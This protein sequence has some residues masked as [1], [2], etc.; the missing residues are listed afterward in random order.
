MPSQVEWL[1][2]QEGF[3]KL[4]EVEQ[5]RVLAQA[6]QEDHQRAIADTRDYPL[7][8][9]RET[10][11]GLG[12]AG[13]NLLLG[14]PQTIASIPELLSRGS[15]LAGKVA[16]GDLP[17]LG[18]AAGAGTKAMLPMP[19]V[20]EAINKREM[21]RYRDVVTDV[22]EMGGSLL[23]GKAISKIPQAF[24]KVAPGAAPALHELAIPEVE[25]FADRFRPP[26]G[27][28]EEAYAR[29]RQMGNPTKELPT[30]RSE[31]AKML[32]EES[33]LSNPDTD[34][35][36]QAQNYLNS[37][38][39][40]WPLDQMVAEEQR[41]GA[42]LGQMRRGP[43]GAT[44]AEKVGGMSR[45]HEDR[46]KR[47]YSALM[48]DS[49][50][51]LKTVPSFAPEVAVPGEVGTA[52]STQTR[53][54]RV[55]IE[56]PI[57]RG[58]GDVEMGRVGDVQVVDPQLQAWHRQWRRAAYLHRREM[59]ANGLKR[60][61]Q[62]SIATVAG[63]DMAERINLRP[64]VNSIRGAMRKSATDPQARLFAESFTRPEL[65]DMIS[66]LKEIQRRL[67]PIPPVAGVATGT[68][69]RALIGS[70]GTL[71]GAGTEALMGG[72]PYMGGMVGGA[73][74]IVAERILSSHYISQALT[75][76]AGRAMVK[77][78]VRVDPT[79]GSTFQHLVGGYLRSQMPGA[80]APEAPEA[81]P[82][83]AAPPAP[84]PLPT[85]PAVR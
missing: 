11:A 15:E 32:A 84:K 28:A 72:S 5:K 13:K 46:I 52:V 78:A 38:D 8:I 30:F 51:A 34:F 71:A 33:R 56:G 58:P 70:I 76:D 50:D 47:M 26:A 40:G 54:G 19:R 16:A 55:A 45:L 17:A 18:Q 73:A 77:L 43:R 22:G 81:T 10:A 80:T 66:T 53:P 20:R 57:A 79:L 49:E 67:P 7:Y 63:G 82:T 24:L 44:P 25:S 14:V 64:V 65:K 21:P 2:Q 60:M 12:K 3:K 39:K 83:A 68:S 23:A 42:M 62:D 36:K 35:I 29:L 41:L 75:T 61:L 48:K 85:P 4:P 37:S 9:A 1:Q 59:A 69:Q 27:A 6:A 31:V 74:S